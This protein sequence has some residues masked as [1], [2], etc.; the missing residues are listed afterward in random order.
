M[1]SVISKRVIVAAIERLSFFIKSDPLLMKRFALLLSMICAL[2]TA[3]PA[4]A[5]RDGRNSRGDEHSRRDQREERNE[6][7]DDNRRRDDYQREHL[8]RE[9]REQLRRD[10]Y[11]HG[12]DIYRDRR[13]R[14]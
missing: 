8:S 9:Q 11:D 6:R 13:E 7:R 3:M 12:R 1:S 10:I 5:Q 2:A 14:R 4:A